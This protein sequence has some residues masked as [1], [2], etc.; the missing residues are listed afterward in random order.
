MLSIHSPQY[1]GRRVKTTLDVTLQHYL[2]VFKENNKAHG[3]LLQHLEV[4]LL[5]TRTV[6][7]Y[8]DQYFQNSGSVNN[9]ASSVIYR[10]NFFHYFQITILTFD[11]PSSFLKDPALPF[12][13]EQNM[14]IIN[15]LC[16][17][18]QLLVKI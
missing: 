12:L 4:D 7:I 2:A 13:K 15:F 5:E 18:F 8:R 16:I 9:L 14:T 11:R 3:N 6:G 17:L 1:F 10:G